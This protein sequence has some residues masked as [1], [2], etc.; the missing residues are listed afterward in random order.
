M[1]F[2]IFTSVTNINEQL[3]FPGVE[4]VI[5]EL[6]LFLYKFSTRYSKI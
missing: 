2:A 4:I 5:L 1:N 6:I 3:N